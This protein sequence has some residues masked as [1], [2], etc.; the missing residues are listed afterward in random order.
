MSLM[1]ED[2]RSRI[3]LL[4]VFLVLAAAVLIAATMSRADPCALRTVHVGH[5]SYQTGDCGD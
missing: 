1:D 3:A 5:T 2:E 4:I